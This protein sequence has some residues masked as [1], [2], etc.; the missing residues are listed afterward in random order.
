MDPHSTKQDDTGR[1]M[2]VSF[3]SS[4]PWRSWLV[5]F[6]LEWRNS[7]MESTTMLRRW[8]RGW[9]PS[10]PDS[11]YLVQ[12]W[13]RHLRQWTRH[14]LWLPWRPAS[15]NWRCGLCRA[16]SSPTIRTLCHRLK[17]TRYIYMDV[18]IYTL[19]THVHVWECRYM[20]TYACMV[21]V[22]H[23]YSIESILVLSNLYIMVT[24]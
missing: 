13:R 18:C 2:I 10:P 17:S 20:C 4:R 1:I 9:S 8:K 15:R 16:E 12:D 21:S 14:R 19:Y 6:D 3:F 5:T 22:F 11:A 7:K 23:K 24:L